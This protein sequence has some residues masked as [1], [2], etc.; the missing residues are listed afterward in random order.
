[1]RIL[2]VEDDEALGYGIRQWLM[3]ESYTVDWVRNGLSAWNAV[4]LEHFDVMILD[5]DLPKKSGIEVLKNIRDR[6]LSLPVMMIS[7]H[8]ELGFRLQCLDLGADDFLVKPFDLAE[9]RSRIKAIYRR[10][11]RSQADGSLKAGP[12]KLNGAK[13]EASLD[14]KPLELPRREFALL[15]LLMENVNQVV[16]L[17]Q[18][19]QSVYG[20][21]RDIGSNALEVHVH[22]L[23]KKIGSQMITTVRGSGYRLVTGD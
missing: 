2:L 6:G 9:L 10:L 19:M 23:R 15:Q 18:A 1:M 13:K 5:I 20:W 4:K 8:K 12:L 21:D 14:G 22:H 17:R 3:G 11:T 16:S 7:G